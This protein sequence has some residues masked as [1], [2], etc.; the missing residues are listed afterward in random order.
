M[1]ND[2]H[3]AGHSAVDWVDVAKRIGKLPDLPNVFKDE[4]DLKVPAGGK[5]RGLD[6]FSGVGGLTLAAEKN[7]V[8]VVC[9][10]ELEPVQAATHAMNHKGAVLNKDITKINLAVLKRKLGRIDVVFGGVPCESFST[11]RQPHKAPSTSPA[12]INN[13]LAVLKTFRPRFFVFEN[14]TRAAKDRRWKQAAREVKRMGYD[15]D[16]WTLR[17]D[18]HGG[19]ATMRKR[20]FFAGQLKGTLASAPDEI[21]GRTLGDVIGSLLKIGSGDPLHAKA[22]RLSDSPF[23]NYTA[24]RSGKTPRFISSGRPLD[25]DKACFT[26]TTQSHEQCLP[27]PGGRPRM[28]TPREVVRLQ[29]FPDD[30]KFLSNDLRHVFKLLGDVVPVGLGSAVFSALLSKPKVGKRMPTIKSADPEYVVDRLA[31][32]GTVGVLSPVEQRGLVGKDTVLAGKNQALGVVQIRAGVRFDTGQRAVKA[33]GNKVDR[34]TAEV[35][36]DGTDP[37]WFHSL[38]PVE[39]F[40]TPRVVKSQHEDDEEEKSMEKQPLTTEARNNLPDSAFLFIRPGGE[41]DET[42][43][44]V[45]RTLRMLPVR[46]ATGAIDLPRLRNA[47]A[48]IPQA[49]LPQATKD[50]LAAEARKLLEETK[51]AAAAPESLVEG[52]IRNDREYAQKGDAD[53]LLVLCAAVAL[54][55]LAEDGTTVPDLAIIRVAGRIAKVELRVRTSTDAGH[56]HVAI[57][58]SET[59]DGK[60]DPGPQDGHVHQIRGWQVLVAAGHTHTISRPQEPSDSDGPLDKREDHRVDFPRALDG[61]GDSAASDEVAKDGG[62]QFIPVPVLKADDELRYAL[63]VVLEPNDGQGGA[64]L[65]PDTQKDVYSAEEIRKASWLYMAKFQGSGVMHEREASKS[66]IVV[67]DNFVTPAKMTIEGTSVRKGTWLQGAVFPSAKIWADVKSGRKGAWSVDGEA[68]RE[69]LAA[70]RGDK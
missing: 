60:T 25:L 9:A 16:L 48:R 62:P 18:R 51:K 28:L 10:V 24:R 31:S 5:L 21:K 37:V 49:D 7:G 36:K 53:G 65:D 6:I 66:E 58:Q 43:R 4:R 14:V 15:A 44:T 41:K 42:G 55:K 17:H 13:A 11:A 46:T 68:L 45:P 1:S 26:I 64:P 61:G 3:L 52:L 30:F 33:L 2:K 32:G 40:D 23:E 70:A 20:L 56:S 54:T 57:V 39:K 38:A 63:G 67:V 29:D 27:H 8:S 35:F 12:L 50:R 22:V 59:G 69:A 19:G 47:L 34:F